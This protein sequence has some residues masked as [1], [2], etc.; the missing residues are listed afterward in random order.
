MPPEKDGFLYWKDPKDQER[1]N[2]ALQ[3]KSMQY[4]KI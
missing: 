3:D 1:H 2:D 4:R